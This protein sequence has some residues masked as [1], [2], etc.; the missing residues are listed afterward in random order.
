[1]KELK[2]W[3][4]LAM[5][6]CLSALAPQ[7]TS[8]S[9]NDGQWV[10]YRQPDGT[11]L[12]VRFCGDEHFTYYVTQTGK[13]MNRGEDGFLKLISKEDLLQEVNQARSSEQTVTKRKGRLRTSWDPEKVYKL[14]VILVS[15]SDEQFKSNHSAAFYDSLFNEPG[16]NKKI[17]PGCVADYFREQSNGLFNASFDIYGPIQMPDTAAC[18]SK[19]G[20]GTYRTVLRKAFI[21]AVDSLAIDLS[22]YDWDGDGLVQQVVFIYAG[23]GGN[24]GKSPR[25]GIINPHTSTFS[26]YESHGV[27]A[28]WYTCSAERWGY[29]DES[30]GIGTIC[31]EFTHALGL[32]DLYP[33]TGSEYSVV[34]EWDL[35]DGGNFT[36][37]GWCPPNYS[38][39][40]KMLLGWQ[41]PVELT[42]PTTITNM[43]SVAEG[44]TVYCISH[45]DDEFFLLENRQQVGW[46]AGIPGKGLAIFHVFYND[47][48]WHIGGD[49]GSNSVNNN[50]NMHRYELVPADN[51][52]YYASLDWAKAIKK[53]QFQNN[54]E[55]LNSNVLSGA[56]YPLVTDTIEN[57]RLTASST[58]A[59]KVFDVVAGGDSIMNK[60][61]TNIQM[62]EDGLISF[63]FMDEVETG[64]SSMQTA[65]CMMHDNIYDLQG[66]KVLYPQPNRLYIRNGRKFIISSNIN[67]NKTNKL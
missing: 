66:R 37:W 42:E 46:D 56:P 44:G 33:T 4:L 31:H 57:R 19:P 62:S 58:P 63:D 30:C 41:T 39:L 11:V 26:T 29:N 2:V 3:L 40:E 36:N 67:T 5:V 48:A 16:F 6:F 21:K 9:R 8:A 64:I 65:N 27:R 38:A 54:V 24:D 18:Y 20:S 55:R 12:T 60:P 1:V 59:M 50:S 10:Q 15:F 17:G 32:P 13:L 43:K 28:N 23:Y 61:I 35:M 34:D 53:Q 52:G 49:G 22:V 51:M 47:V 25:K 45:T 14:P 7:T